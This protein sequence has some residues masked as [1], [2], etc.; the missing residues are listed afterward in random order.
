MNFS[1][2]HLVCTITG[3]SSII[4]DF[5]ELLSFPKSDKQNSDIVFE[6]VENL[7]VWKDEH[8]TIDNFNI[9]SDKI[10]VKDEFFIYEIAPT[11]KPFHVL[12]SF[13]KKKNFK[14][15]YN[16]L[17]RNWRYF[18][19][20]GR[21]ASIF[22]LRRFLFHIYMPMMQ[23]ALLRSNAAL[24]HCS[25]IEKNG[26]AILFPAWGGVGKT[27]IM[28][29]YIDDGWRFIADDSCIIC[30]DGTAFTHP[31][32]MHIYK[33]HAVQSPAIVDKMLK[34]VPARDRF[35]WNFISRFKRPDKLVRWIGPD[36]VFGKD[37]LG[38]NGKIQK[39]IHLHR[40]KHSVDFQIQQ[41]TPPDLARVMA[42]TILDEINGLVDLSIGSN[43]GNLS[44]TSIIPDVSGIYT[45][46]ADI[47]A[48]AFSSAC[49]FMLSLPLASTA[50][51]LYSFLS[52]KKIVI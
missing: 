9:S 14:S 35:L 15:I 48:K 5:A 24:A 20:H 11:Q 41:T 12:V 36:K 46:T 4:E 29:R 23:L 31:L 33:Y 25:A 10:R 19:L 21:S 28:G 1:V 3:K 6:F 49:C 42:S 51:E 30:A 37:K 8:V 17:K 52:D 22:F 47:Y 50:D 39:V 16:N 7:P 26:N 43:S 2:G 38:Q 45:K 32:P 34:N 44:G 13:I 27:S 40:I 18:H